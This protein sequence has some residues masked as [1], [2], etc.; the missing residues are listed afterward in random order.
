LCE[1]HHRE[2][3]TSSRE[4]TLTL[5]E[6]CREELFNRTLIQKANKASHSLRTY[7]DYLSDEKKL[8]YKNLLKYT[9]GEILSD[10]QILLNKH[11]E[12]MI[13]MF[14]K[15]DFLRWMKSKGREDFKLSR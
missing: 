7:Y 13:C 5:L 8:E 11:G 2:Y 12:E 14:W 1:D 3:E 9:D 10:S 15:K 4:L 6:D